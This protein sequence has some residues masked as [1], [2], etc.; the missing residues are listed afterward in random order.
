MSAT[1]AWM[2][3]VFS[4]PRMNAY[5]VAAD[6]D[7]TTAWRLY[8]WNVAVSGAFYGPLHCLEIALRNAMHDALRTGFAREDWWTAAPLQPHGQRL[9][10]EARTKCHRSRPPSADDIVASCRS[11]SGPPC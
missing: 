8:T 6:Q 9:V 5:L 4:A 7:P 11:G 1:P 2:H 3:K 10:N